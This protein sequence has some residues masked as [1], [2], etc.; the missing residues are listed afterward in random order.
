MRT[1]PTPSKS[2]LGQSS[3][4]LRN[5][6]TEAFDYVNPADRSLQKL[7]GMKTVGLSLSKGSL[8]SFFGLLAA[9]C[10]KQVHRLDIADR[11]SEAEAQRDQGLNITEQV[12]RD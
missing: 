7:S 4:G 5:T 6:E 12:D 9:V 2:R 11:H 8:R 10:V 1:C 3:L